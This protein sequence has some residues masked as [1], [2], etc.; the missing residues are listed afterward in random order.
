[1][2]DYASPLDFNTFVLLTSVRL[3]LVISPFGG[4]NGPVAETSRKI[5]LTDYIMHKKWLSTLACFIL[6]VNVS[7]AQEGYRVV[8]KTPVINP[9]WPT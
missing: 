7:M 8:L 3:I 2:T 6:V 4:L 9:A 5:P 1:M